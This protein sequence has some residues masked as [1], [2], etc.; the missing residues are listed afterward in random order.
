MSIEQKCGWEQLKSLG[1]L[2]QVDTDGLKNFSLSTQYILSFNVK[3]FHISLSP[4][5]DEFGI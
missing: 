5:I 3:A 2:H 4:I 1:R